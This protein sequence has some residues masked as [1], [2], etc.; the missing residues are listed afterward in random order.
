MSK[1]WDERDKELEDK[2]EKMMNRIEKLMDRFN[3]PLPQPIMPAMF[4]Q[5]FVAHVI[6]KDGKQVIVLPDDVGETLLGKFIEVNINE[7]EVTGV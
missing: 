1:D 3:T 2:P 6:T 4:L 7:I 5:K